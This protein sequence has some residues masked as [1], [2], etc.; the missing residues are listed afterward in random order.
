LSAS[1]QHPPILTLRRPGGGRILWRCFS[2]L[3]PYWRTTLAAYSTLL[4]INGLNIAVPL[5]IRAMVD[6]GMGRQD[7]SFLMWGSLGLL[8][9]TIVKGL[10]TFVQGY[11]T[12]AASQSVAYD[13]RNAIHSKLQSLSFSYHDRAET[14][15]L[16]TR[17]ISDVDRIRFLT[18]RASLRLLDAVVLFL[19][20]AI[21]LL[22]LN[23]PLAILAL[24]T[25][26]ALIW[27]G[28]M[29]GWYTSAF[30]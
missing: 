20:T 26:L 13:L 23:A 1:N 10:L 22:Q 29:W 15:Q 25:M 4:V 7:L 3:R 17:A 11:L 5:I 30:R 6:R 2:Y 16:L 21:V 18:G 12:E 9:L 19:G 14:G 27:G 28:T 8:G 24:G